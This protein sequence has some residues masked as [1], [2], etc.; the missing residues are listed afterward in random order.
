MFT[1]LIATL[2]FPIGVFCGYI[3]SSWIDRFKAAWKFAKFIRLKLNDLQ[4]N[5]TF[6]QQLTFAWKD[7][8]NPAKVVEIADYRFVKEDS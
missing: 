4:F 6:W 2:S 7:F 5:T 1:L 8:R 3:F